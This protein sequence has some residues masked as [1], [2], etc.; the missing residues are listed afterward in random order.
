MIYTLIFIAYI[1]GI[2]SLAWYF[3]LSGFTKFHRK[4]SL[5][6]YKNVFGSRRFFVSAW[7]GALFWI[8]ERKKQINMIMDEDVERVVIKKESKAIP[9]MKGA[10]FM[11][12]LSD[13]QQDEFFGAVLEASPD[14]NTP[15]KRKPWKF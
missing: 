14:F 12:M 8:P 1:V 9:G 4:C 3:R 2:S 6:I 10:E 11:K 15:T 13:E 7:W 5:S